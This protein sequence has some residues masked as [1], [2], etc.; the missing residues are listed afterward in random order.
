MA[1]TFIKSLVLFDLS[2][3]LIIPVAFMVQPGHY[4]YR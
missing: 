1:A 2:Y 3:P 4:E